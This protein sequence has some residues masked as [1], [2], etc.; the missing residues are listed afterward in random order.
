MF[1]AHFDAS[2]TDRK[3]VLTVAGCV[4]NVDR[5][6]KFEP[7]WNKAI[8][9]NGLPKGTVFHMTD[10]V[11]S[12]SPFDIFRDKPAE[13]A[14]L[15]EDLV[16]C[17]TTHVAIV[18]SVG[19]IIEQ[20]NAFDEHWQLRETYGAP[21]SFASLIAVEKTLDWLRKKRRKAATAFFFEKGDQHQGNFEQLCKRYY[22][23]EPEC[24]S[25]TNMVQ[26][27]PC[28]LVAWKYCKASTE[29]AQ[30]GHTGDIAKLRSILKSLDPIRAINGFSGVFDEAA[31]QKMCRTAGIKPR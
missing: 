28:D 23:F 16:A 29:A 4:S 12:I 11:S 24:L 15:I 1:S 18:F 19:V 22:G 2:G 7:A 21:Y 5:W 10:F 6:V 3:S 17:V 25:K 20:Y 14:K 8:V 26:F 9:A 30:H 13:R 27:Q 31:L